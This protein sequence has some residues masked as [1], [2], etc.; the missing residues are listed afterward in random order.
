[1]LHCCRWAEETAD[2]KFSIRE[3]GCSTLL[4]TTKTFRSLQVWVWD[5]I[6]LS[7]ERSDKKPKRLLLDLLNVSTIIL[8]YLPFEARMLSI[9]YWTNVTAC[10]QAIGKNRELC[11]FN[12]LSPPSLSNH[13]LSLHMNLL[14]YDNCFQCMLYEF[15][16]RGTTEKKGRPFSLNCSSNFCRDNRDTCLCAAN[17]LAA[18]CMRRGL[19]EKIIN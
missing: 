2:R 12:N 14:C 19:K 15:K 10:I 17:N 4:S 9:F 8:N 5:D 7:Y 13:S 3:F 11:L 18:D 1:M 6:S 16:P